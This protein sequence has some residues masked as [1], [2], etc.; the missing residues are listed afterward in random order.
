MNSRI[1]VAAGGACV[2]LAAGGLYLHGLKDD[3]PPIDRE[4][5]PP[6]KA[7]VKRSPL[8]VSSA[9][10]ESPVSPAPVEEKLSEDQRKMIFAKIEEASVTYDPKGLPLLEPYLLHPDPEVRT[11][12]LNG[13][14][15]LGEAAAAPMLREAAKKAPNPKEAVALTEAADYLELPAGSFIPAERTAEGTRLPNSG[16]AGKRSRPKLGVARERVKDPEAS[17]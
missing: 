15:V 17:R 10:P 9:Q 2:L 11:A 12:A 16:E 4:T 5:P 13:M 1:L 14:I 7:E 6:A 3:V 8:P